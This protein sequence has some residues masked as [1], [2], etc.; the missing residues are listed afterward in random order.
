LKNIL[1]AQDQASGELDVEIEKEQGKGNFEKAKSWKI[2]EFKKNGYI[3]R[4][5]KT[6][7]IDKKCSYLYISGDD[8]FFGRNEKILIENGT[9]LMSGKESEEI[10]KKIDDLENQASS[11]LG[12][13]FG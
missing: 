3:L 6:L 12:F 1:E 13:I 5:A 7:G 10:Q 11:G 9:K 2:N 8:D 4:D